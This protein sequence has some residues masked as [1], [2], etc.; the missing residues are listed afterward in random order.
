MIALEIIGGICLFTG[1]VICIIGGV[2][3]IRMRSFFGRV[4]AASVPDT[5][6]AGLCLLGMVLFTIAWPDPDYTFKLK[7]LI[8]IKLFSIGAFI[9]VTSP[10]AGHAV[11]KAAWNQGI[12]KEEEERA[13]D[14]R[15]AT[16]NGQGEQI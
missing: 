10:I 5:L 7:A 11:S 12:G 14:G 2:G 1:T 8:V 4:H 13:I 6:G 15:A 3:L 9:F 16:T